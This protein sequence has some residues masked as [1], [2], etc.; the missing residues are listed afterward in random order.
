MTYDSVAKAAVFTILLTLGAT[1]LWFVAVPVTQSWLKDWSV[2][3]PVDIPLWKRA[4]M[5][6]AISWP[7]VWPAFVVLVWV[8]SFLPIELVRRIN[9]RRS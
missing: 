8:M 4:M 1:A 2:Q 9:A 7:K 3:P 6:L 5:L